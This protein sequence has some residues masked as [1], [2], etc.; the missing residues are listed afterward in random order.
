MNSSPLADTAPEYATPVWATADRPDVGVI[1]TTRDPSD[2]ALD[3]ALR[4]AEATG[5][6]VCLMGCVD[7]TGAPRPAEPRDLS[8]EAREQL[9]RIRARCH[10]RRIDVGV[11]ERLHIGSLASM[12]AT[13]EDSLGVMII[14]RSPIAAGDVLA[15]CPIAVT[16]VG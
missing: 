2:Q 8:A 4:A 9:G 1:I 6:R 3:A 15:R 13:S 12:L 14:D 5:G 7:T 10:A 16:A 11:Y